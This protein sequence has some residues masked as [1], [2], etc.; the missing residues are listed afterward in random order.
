MFGRR[1]KIGAI[2]TVIRIVCTGG[3]AAGAKTVHA[4]C[5]HP[6]DAAGRGDALERHRDALARRD[7]RREHAEIVV[8][9]LVL[10]R[11]RCAVDLQ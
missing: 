10:Q 4:A 2:R 1:A 6:L 5:C 3:L 7:E 8:A 9:R 11:T